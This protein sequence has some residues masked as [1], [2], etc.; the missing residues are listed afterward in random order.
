MARGRARG[1]VGVA[2][3]GRAA[4][5]HKARLE[6]SNPHRAP[7]R[8]RRLVSGLETA[9]A[10]AVRG[11]APARGW[12]RGGAS[13]SARVSAG[14]GWAGVL[15]RV[16]AGLTASVAERGESSFLSLPTKGSFP[17]VGS[18]SPQPGREWGRWR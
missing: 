10:G 12:G 14:A 7:R 17:F 13:G 8:L 5:A 1:I 3:P 6:D 16:G 11:L 15:R 18:G 4:A 9:G 2:V